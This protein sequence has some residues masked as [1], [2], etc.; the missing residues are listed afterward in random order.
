MKIR[1][2][3]GI[4]TLE[5]KRFGENGFTRFSAAMCRLRHFCAALV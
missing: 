5:K 1:V 4:L 3:C 2:V